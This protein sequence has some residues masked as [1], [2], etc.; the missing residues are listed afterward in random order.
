MSNTPAHTFE[1][2]HR[3]LMQRLEAVRSNLYREETASGG[4]TFLVCFTCLTVAASLIEYAFSCPSA[5]RAALVFTWALAS[6]ALAGT[7]LAIP[8]LKM[9][10]ILRPMTLDE[11]AVIVGRYFPSIND[12]LRNLLQLAGDNS[13]DQLYSAELL[14]ASLQEFARRSSTFNFSDAVSYARVSRFARVAGGTV[15]AALLIFLYPGSPISSAAYRLAHFRQEFRAPLPYSLVVRPGDCSVIKNGSVPIAIQVVPNPQAPLTFAS[16]RELTLVLE[17]QGVSTPETITL[18]RDTA[19]MFTYVLASVKQSLVYTAVS[20]E[21]HSDRYSIRVSDRPFVRSFTTRILPPRYAHLPELQLDENIGDASAL[22]GSIVSWEITPSKD[23]QA[24][25]VSI[26]G[27]NAIP[28]AMQNGK[29]RGTMTLLSTVAYRLNLQDR[30]GVSNEEPIRYTL[31]VVPDVPPTIAI[32]APGKNIDLVEDMKVPLQI[33]ITD[34]YGFSSLTLY[35]RLIHSKYEQPQTEF[36]RIAI[37]IPSGTDKEQLASYLWDVSP[38]HLVPEDVIEYHAEVADNDAVSGPKS[39]KSDSYLLRLPSLDEVFADADKSHDDAVKTLDES[40]KQAEELKKEIEELDRDFKRNQ[41]PDWQKQKKAD[42]LVKQYEDIQKKI[43]SVNKTVDAMTQDLQKNKLLSPE[44]LQKYA[45]LQQLMQQMN[46]PEFMD[47]LKKMQEAMKNA[48]PEQLRQA[49]QNMQLSEEAFRNSIERTMNLLKR[50]QVEQ[51]TDELVKRAAE[52]QKNEEQLQKETSQ[53]SPS[54]PEKSATLAKKQDDLTGDLKDLQQEIDKLKKKM[55]ELG[56]QMP[57]EKMEKAQQSAN[58]KEM[59]EAM[60]QASQQL[61]SNQKAQA[62]MNQQKAGKSM[63]QMSQNL[64]EMQEQLLANQMAEAMNGLRKAMENM[65]DV[66]EK[67]EQLKNQTQQLDPNSPQFR[68]N[69]DQQ[70][71]LQGDLSSIA[72]GLAD[73]SQ[74]SFVVTPEMGK[75][76]GKA[77]GEMNEALNGLEQRNGQPASGHQGEAM[78]SLNR[79]ATIVQNAMKELQQGGGSGGGSLMQQLQRMSAQQAGINS[80]TQQIG[81]G[82]AQ[83]EGRSQQELA[84]MA[85]LAAEQQAVQ[86]SMEQ[87]NREAQTSPDRDRILG[88]L[89]KIADEMKEVVQSLAQHSAGEQTI[90][91]QD[92]ILSRM[93]NAQ[94]SLRERDYEQKRKSTTGTSLVRKSPAELKQDS[95]P[96]GLSR[97]LQRA[98]ES[99]YTKEYMDLIRRY[100]EALEKGK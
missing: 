74:K 22:A 52:L 46:S 67:Q 100:Y 55:E 92:R 60:K 97:D 99:G 47:A 84:Q 89:K 77:M 1:A 63:Q 95:A 98:A 29:L 48:N 51:K 11:T 83:Q 37:P 54:E 38:L 33:K 26:E 19:G 36:N 76:L 68:E 44:T 93:L 15:A 70:M 3:H 88:D 50:L 62:M 53:L 14:G 18:R 9:S 61:K 91:K 82:Q 30:D 17:Q 24:A 42:D 59:E 78:A 16:P 90:Q 81:Q 5:V 86:K 43:E 71:N 34:D 41:T 21:I 25:S 79:G 64:S 49:M 94:R 31:T 72:N 96:T 13:A 23:I 75:A 32:V 69:A 27:G 8:I 65:L 45:E 20:G 28:L 4:L 12:H 57:M 56:K 6:I 35:Y 85:R 73:L 87:L 58:D 66:S 39:A 80:Q 10:G 40:L 7:L 2:D